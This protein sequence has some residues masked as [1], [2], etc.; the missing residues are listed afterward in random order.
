MVALDVLLCFLLVLVSGLIGIFV[1]KIQSLNRLF[2]K[3]V[4]KE[5]KKLFMIEV[6][7]MVS[8]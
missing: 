2:D 7:L 8:C 3:R 4:E 6:Q 1:L 5:H